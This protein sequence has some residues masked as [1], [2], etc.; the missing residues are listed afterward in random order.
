MKDNDYPQLMPYCLS[1]EI[2]QPNIFSVTNLDMSNIVWAN[3][4]CDEKVCKCREARKKKHEAKTYPVHTTCILCLLQGDARINCF[5]YFM[6]IWFVQDDAF[7]F[8]QTMIAQLQEI[9][10][11][12]GEEQAPPPAS[13]LTIESLPSNPVT[14][15]QIGISYSSTSNL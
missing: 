2:D 8:P 10:L 9:N 11:G 7:F 14:D 6:K 3:S 13:V 15:Q 5:Q 4:R 12:G 1:Y